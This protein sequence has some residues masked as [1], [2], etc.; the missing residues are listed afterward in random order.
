[1]H[2]IAF[3]ATETL[4]EVAPGVTQLMWTFNDQ[5]PG[6]MLHGN[7]G[8]TFRITLTNKGEMGHSIDFHASKVAWNDEMR[9][10]L[11]GESLVYEFEAPWSTVP[12]APITA[13]PA[14][15]ANAST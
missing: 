9:T 2:E 5:V 4:V 6:P 7:V 11:P 12:W 13:A 15:R 14:T 10:I 1:M 3:D 8:D